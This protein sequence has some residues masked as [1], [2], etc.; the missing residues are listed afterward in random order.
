MRSHQLGLPPATEAWSQAQFGGSRAASLQPRASACGPACDSRGAHA[1][2]NVAGS[3]V[4]GRSRTDILGRGEPNVARVMCCAVWFAP[5]ALDVG[6]HCPNQPHHIGPQKPGQ[7]TAQLFAQQA[8]R[9]KPGTVPWCTHCTALHNA[10]HCSPS[11]TDTLTHPSWQVQ[12]H[13]TCEHAL[14]PCF[15]MHLMASMTLVKVR[16]HIPCWRARP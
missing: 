14:G 12:L 11:R 15:L 10:L 9:G 2:R 16:V 6:A 1:T 5:V 8:S 7:S 4:A 13:C 3:V